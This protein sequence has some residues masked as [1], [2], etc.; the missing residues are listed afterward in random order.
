MK[1]LLMPPRLSNRMA[2][3]LLLLR[4]LVGLAFMFHGW[5]KITNPFGW[6]GPQSSFPP[7]LLALAAVSEF[8]G[9]AAWILGLLTPLASL[10]IASTMT[11]AIWQ[12]ALVKQDPF[13]AVG[14]SSYESAAVYLAIAI[15]FLLTG[16]GR[17]S[18]DR[19][20]FGEKS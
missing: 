16:P 14:R 7:P 18:L 4:V 13:V 19:M 10:G 1:Q 6:M 11:V 12:H 5:P 9:G 15:L 17:F 2:L 8:G 20:I 3:G